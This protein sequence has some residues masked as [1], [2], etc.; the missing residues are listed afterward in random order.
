MSTIG[1]NS[2]DLILNADGGSSTIKLKINGTEKA[3]VSSAGAFTSTTIDA[4]KL[5]GNLP[6]ISAANLTAIPA[7]NITGTLPAISGASLTGVNAVN[8][9]RKNMI[10]NG[11]MRINQRGAGS[12]TINSGSLQY[13]CDRFAARGVSSAGVFTIEKV[14]D[15]PAG[16]T[17]SL[18]ATVTTADSSLSGTESYRIVQHIEGN[19]SYYLNWGSSDNQTATLSFKVKSSLTGTFGG[20]VQNGDY[21]RFVPFTY[22]ISS[23]NTWEDKTV[24]I[25]GDTTGTYQ[26][27]TALAVRLNWSLGAAQLGTAGT[28][29]GSALNGATGQTQ[30]IST[31]GATWQVTGVQLE[32]GSVATDFEY[33]SYG[34]ELALCERYY[35]VITGGIGM[36]IVKS[37]T[38]ADCSF[39]PKVNK[40]AAPTITLAGTL[41]ANDGSAQQG[42]SLS[43]TGGTQDGLI[44]VIAFSSLNVGRACMFYTSG[45]DGRLIADSEL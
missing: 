17:N 45:L 42:A 40:R 29:S 31:N 38:A 20:V 41:Y 7:A 11:G 15:S 3:S 12:L 28:Y 25:T 24:T 10:I 35:E 34:E 27:D 36:G 19:N 14:T 9:G 21:N 18:K 4:T 16:F 2:E 22:T 30:V 32:L 33:R 8:G 13:P 44:V 6:A 23:A 39:Q 43:S 1:S 26:T 5:T 37:S